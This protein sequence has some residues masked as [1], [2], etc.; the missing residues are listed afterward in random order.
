[1]A[2]K[3]EQSPNNF[4]ARVS[5]CTRKCQYIMTIMTV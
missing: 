4:T 2:P 3:G 1:M 5:F